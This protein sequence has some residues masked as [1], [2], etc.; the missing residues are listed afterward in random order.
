MRLKTLTALL[1]WAGGLLGAAHIVLTPLVYPGW[2][3]DTLWFLGTGLAIVSTATA[4]HLGHLPRAKRAWMVL[5][6]L[7]VVMSGYFAAAW[8]VI[9]T[10]QVVIGGLL[11]LGLAACALAGQ[12]YDMR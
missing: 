1:I 9:P 4:N 7:N 11:F 3:I 6:V 8:S 10:P 12:R 5:V 2:T